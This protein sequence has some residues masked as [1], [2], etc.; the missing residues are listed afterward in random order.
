MKFIP[1]ALV[2]SLLA[3]I[4]A[5]AEENSF[6]E[7]GNG[8]FS[9]QGQLDSTDDIYEYDDGDH[10]YDTWPIYGEA[11]EQL[12]ISVES[13]DFDAMVIVLAVGE[14]GVE[15]VG[16]NDDI[17]SE[18]T[19]SQIDINVTGSGE[20]IV[21]VLPY[22]PLEQ[23][24]YTVGIQAVASAPN[25]TPQLSSEQLS[26]MDRIG[27]QAVELNRVLGETSWYRLLF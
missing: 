12:K 20:F 27:Q 18:T 11:G 24:A 16:A 15:L 21:A 4:P 26:E 2:M 25:A 23:G 17:N 13:S 7:R 1:L 14:N 5:V 22:N 19:N 9:G 10:Y 8:F 6:I 3:A